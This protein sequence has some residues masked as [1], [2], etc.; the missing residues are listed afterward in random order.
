MYALIKLWTFFLVFLEIQKG[1][2]AKSYTRTGFKGKSLR[3]CTGPVTVMKG[4]ES[5]S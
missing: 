5:E 1:Q 3:S 2:G 4:L